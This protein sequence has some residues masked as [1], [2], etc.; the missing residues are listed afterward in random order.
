MQDLK[1]QQNITKVAS[2]MQPTALSDT[3]LY[4]L[5]VNADLPFKLKQAALMEYEKRG[6]SELYI[7]QLRVNYE[8]IIP[9]DHS[10]LLVIEKVAIIVFPFIILYIILANRFIATNIQKWR[11]YWVYLAIG[12]LVWMM[13]VFIVAKVV[14]NF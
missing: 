3:Q 10:R 1:N 9:A 13:M 14:L 2:P 11:A 5:V 7:F 4:A 8:K 6:F 12:H